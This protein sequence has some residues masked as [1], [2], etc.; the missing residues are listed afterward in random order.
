MLVSVRAGQQVLDASWCEAGASTENH[1][2][3]VPA[4]SIDP[5]SNKASPCNT[6]FVED[7]RVGRTGHMTP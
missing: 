4:A 2:E 3:G 6:Q 1:L 5:K 7:P